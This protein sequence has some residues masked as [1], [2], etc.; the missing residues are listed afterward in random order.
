MQNLD[1]VIYSKRLK[2]H[3]L[4]TIQHQAY[5]LRAARIRTV[6]KTFSRH[7]GS[8]WG[9]YRKLQSP[10]RL[11]DSS[12]KNQGASRK[13]QITRLVPQLSISNFRG[14]GIKRSK[15][16]QHTKERHN[17]SCPLHFQLMP[18]WK[19]GHRPLKGKQGTRATQC[20]ENGAS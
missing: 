20:D 17:A 16:P 19:R 8:M 7:A 4:P 12:I 5:A 13:L 14:A 11:G 9:A 3:D 6:S 10:P 1:H 18:P 15:P 2:A